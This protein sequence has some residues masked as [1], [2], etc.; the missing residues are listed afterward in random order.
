MPDNQNEITQAMDILLQELYHENEPGAAV[1]VAKDGK[2]IFRKGYGMANVELQVPNEPHMVFRLGSITKQFTAVC[3]LMLY[4]QGKLGLQ[5]DITKYLPDYPTHGHT[6]TIEHLLTHTSGIK[7][8]T[9]MQDWT[10]VKRKDFTVEEMIN[11]FKYQPMEFAPGE[12]WNY[13]NSGYFLLGAIIEKVS[14]ISYADFVQ[15]N[16]F[17]PLGMNNSYYDMPNLI[18]PNRAAGYTPTAEGFENTDYLSMTQPYAAGSL[19]STVDDMLLWDEALYTE[20]LLKQETLELAWTPCKL[21]GG[22]R[23]NYGYGWA[24]ADFMGTHVIAHSGGINGFTTDGIRFPDEHAYAIILTNT[25]KVIPD[26]L[27]YKLAALAAD[28]P[29]QEPE[30]VRVA[31]E[32]LQRYAAVYSIPVFHL[33]VPVEYQDGKLIA[34]IPMAPNSELKAISETDFFIT[35]SA[36]RLSFLLNEGNQ[37]TG[38]VLTGIYGGDLKGVKTDKPLP[39]QRETITLDPAL[40]QSYAGDYQISPGVVVKVLLENDSLMAI[41]PGQPKMQLHAESEEVFFMKE[42][43]VTVTFI[44]DATG[45]TKEIQIDLGGQEMAAQKIN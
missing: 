10:P 2:V 30:A 45:Q 15:K 6:I 7:S 19:A 40:L 44:K 1:L 37:V 12:Q 4:E 31:P 11:F 35:D 27:A 41:A 42:A 22:E 17:D 36:Y 5:D 29:Y 20:K 39:S 13:N 14:G 9:G 16:I 23:M 34:Q 24:I 28:K 33:E 38:C 43:P 21:N 26:L 32:I 18:I 8:Y 25:N 3:I